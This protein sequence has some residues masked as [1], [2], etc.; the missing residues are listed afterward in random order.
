MLRHFTATAFVIDSQKQVLLLWHKRL[1]RWMPPGG[2]VDPN[3][4]PEEAARRECKE[5]TDIDVEIVGDPYD[6][7]FAGNP[8]EGKMLKKPIAMLLENIPA[9]PER[10]EPAHQHMDFLFIARP[11]DEMQIPKI[12][13]DESNEMKWFSREEIQTLDEKTEIFSNV[14]AY[15]LKLV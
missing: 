10:N 11:L 2:H 3:E 9:S 4:T 5:E 13:H 12:N 8:H 1:Q 6:D 15:I 7:L 14:K